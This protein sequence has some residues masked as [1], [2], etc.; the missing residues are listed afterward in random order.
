MG[1]AVKDM[2]GLE[3]W[4]HRQKKG[5]EGGNLQH[6][7]KNRSEIWYEAKLNSLSDMIHML[8]RGMTWCISST[9]L[10]ALMNHG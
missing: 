6:C 5:E 9:F 7:S 3:E 8:K 10:R 2:G 1:I 4:E